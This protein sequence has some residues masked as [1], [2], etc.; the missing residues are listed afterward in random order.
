MK[1]RA[2]SQQFTCPEAEYWQIGDV[3]LSGKGDRASIYIVVGRVST[4][5]VLV[6][7]KRDLQK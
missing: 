6:K 5:T 7:F 4:V 2:A 1:L 3:I